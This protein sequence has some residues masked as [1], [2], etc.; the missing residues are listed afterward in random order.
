MIVT[1]NE[2]YTDW[3]FQGVHMHEEAAT[4]GNG[5]LSGHIYFRYAT[6]FLKEGERILRSRSFIVLSDS[7]TYELGEGAVSSKVT[8]IDHGLTSGGEVHLEVRGIDGS[9]I[10]VHSI[11]RDVTIE[12]DDGKIPVLDEDQLKVIMSGLHDSLEESMVET[13]EAVKAE[14]R[15][16]LQTI[17]IDVK[18]DCTN[19]VNASANTLRGE[20]ASAVG[21]VDGR[22]STV[23]E[24]VTTVAESVTALNTTMDNRVII[25]QGTTGQ[26]TIPTGAYVN[27]L[28]ARFDNTVWTHPLMVHDET[29]KTLRLTTGISTR[30]RIATFTWTGNIR[31]D[32]ENF[33]GY[34]YMMVKNVRGDALAVS[35]YFLSREKGLPANLSRIQM[36]VD[37]FIKAN[38]SAAVLEEGVRIEFT[39]STGANVVLTSGGELMYRVIE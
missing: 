27:I 14:L 11:T 26:Y 22:V 12:Y 35:T 30:N 37:L 15:E 29:Q 1:R 8:V 18:Q 20:I 21:V 39:R 32:A 9:G 25:G 31:F 34:V 38:D 17:A 28:H 6:D 7:S 19:T 23:D 13:A 10:G 24:R 3:L 4:V 2:R 16:E 5:L 36:S 33:N